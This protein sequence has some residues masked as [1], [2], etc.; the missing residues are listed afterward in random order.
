MEFVPKIKKYSDHMSENGNS[1]ILNLKKDTTNKVV[2]FCFV[3]NS[4]KG[5]GGLVFI[6][7]DHR[8]KIAS[9][10]MEFI[11]RLHLSIKFYYEK[12]YTFYFCSLFRELEQLHAHKQWGALQHVQ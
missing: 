3:D 5:T 2:T 9:S 8:K 7:R 4:R 6:L 12:H 1:L 10:F 11:F